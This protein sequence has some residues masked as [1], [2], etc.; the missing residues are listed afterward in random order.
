[1]AGMSQGN[2]YPEYRSTHSISPTF[3]VSHSSTHP[4]VPGSAEVD[5]WQTAVDAA[6]AAVARIDTATQQLNKSSD[7]RGRSWALPVEPTEQA[8]VPVWTSR[9]EWLR[10]FRHHINTP[11]GKALCARRLIKPDK[12]YSVAEAHAYFAESRTGRGVTAAKSTIAARAKVSE[13]TVNRARRVLIDLEMGIEHVRGRNLKTL[14][15]LAAEAHHG[16]QQHRA[17]STWSLSSPRG[18]VVA[19]PPIKAPKKRLSRSVERTLRYRASRAAVTGSASQELTN[20]VPPA[21]MVTDTLSSVG[22]LSCEV[23]PLGRT[24]QRAHAGIPAPTN[25]MKIKA[26]GEPRPLELQR[27]AAELITHA[28]ALTPPG[29]IGAVCDILRNAGVDPTR[30]TGRDIARTLSRDT[31]QRGWIWPTTA[32]LTSPLAYLRR[33]LDAIDWTGKSPSEQRKA[34]DL[35]RRKEQ[36]QLE[37]TYAQRAKTAANPEHRAKVL[38]GIRAHLTANLRLR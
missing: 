35:A 13:S 30:W 26:A 21:T 14:E 10:Q 15:Y 16:G 31:A 33:R 32:S 20:Q 11:A 8:R 3:G 2:A 28:P 17:A 38:A 12:A 4:T 25:K 18:V 34:A 6:L 1:M 5:E 36:E 19:T 27:A 9:C 37:T 22:F 7:Q 23:L 24:H 29:H